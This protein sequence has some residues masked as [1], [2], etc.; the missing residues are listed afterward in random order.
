MGWWHIGTDALAS[1]RF[2]VSPLAE[3]CAA[4]MTL[5][6]G[7]GA[8]PGE[9]AWLAAR[10]P[11]YRARLAA[12][13]VDALLVR[14]AI[15]RT[16]NADFLTPTPLGEGEPSFEE[17]VAAVRDAE[18]GDAVPQLEVAVGG[19]VPEPLRRAPDL[20]RR[21]AGI[22]EWVWRETVL[23]EWPRRR[24][25]LEADVVA[26]TAL[27][28]RGGWAA[29]LD[30]LCPG[31]MRWLGDGRLQINTRDYPPRSVEGARLLFV[32]VTPAKGWCSWA[33]TERYA[34]TY[35][36]QGALADVSGPGAPQALAA[37]LGR[38]RAGVLVRLE[39][40]A[41]TS[42]LVAL[43]GQ[44]L[45]SVGRHLKVLLDAGLVRR[46]R[47]GRSVLYDRTEAGT[48]LVRAAREGA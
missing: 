43:T 16:W 7:R 22:L 4:L 27:L 38:A 34:V 39:S 26:R 29:A 15:G 28:G 5:H 12:D 42:Q 46:R 17:E 20:P 47:A 6:A 36:C 13:P 23:P 19:P 3:A 32:P 30:E 25:V 33:G 11:A 21:M 35:A 44:G 14:A 24:R 48:V 18:P 8:H 2:V 1:S 37:L 40:P 41:S 31:K 9:R 45:G 10:L